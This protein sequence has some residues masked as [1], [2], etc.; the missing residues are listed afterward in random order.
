MFGIGTALAIVIDAT[1]IRGVVVPA[2][3]RVTG[4]L[5]WWAPSPLKW[6][7]ARIGFTE[8]TSDTTIPSMAPQHDEETRR[9]P[10]MGAGTGHHPAPEADPSAS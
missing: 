1:V 6:L 9:L 3:L 7:H 8:A 5:N 2:F 10:A 4:E